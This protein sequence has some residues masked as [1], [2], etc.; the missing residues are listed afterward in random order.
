MNHTEEQAVE[1]MSELGLNSSLVKFMLSQ[2][3]VLN[4]ALLRLKLYEKQNVDEK[5]VRTGL[6]SLNNQNI[7]SLLDLLYLFNK[8]ATSVKTETKKSVVKEE[9]VVEEIHVEQEEEQEEVNEEDNEDE[10]HFDT[11]FNQC[12]RR[13]DDISDSVKLSE[14]YNVFTKWWN[15]HYEDEVPGKDELKDF[16]SEKLGVKVKSTITHVNLI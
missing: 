6:S 4:M 5:T 1:M 14:M 11:F 15:N 16:F 9:K 8:Q 13:T 2:R 3:N 12:V 7:S 10:S